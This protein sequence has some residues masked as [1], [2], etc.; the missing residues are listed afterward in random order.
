MNTVLPTAQALARWIDDNGYQS[1][2][3]PREI[4]LECPENHD[5]WVTELQAPVT[6]N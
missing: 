3:Y 4:N 2:G 6:R 5:H 1:T